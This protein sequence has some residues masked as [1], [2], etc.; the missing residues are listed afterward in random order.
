MARLNKVCP[1]LPAADVNEAARWYRDK[2]GFTINRIYPEHGFAIVR[3]RDDI[4]I[5]FWTCKERRIAE[6]TSAYFR[7]DD[8]NALHATLADA[9]D[10]GRLSEVADR[11]WGMREFYVWDPDGNLLKFGVPTPAAAE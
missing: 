5:H 1:Q 4:E 2:L 8:I 11:A 3:R 6:H 10:G 7:V 9:N